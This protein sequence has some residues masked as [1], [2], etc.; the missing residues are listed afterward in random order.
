MRISK[1]DHN[2]RTGCNCKVRKS[3]KMGGTSKTGLHKMSTD[4]T[5]NDQENTSKTCLL[6]TLLVVMH[7]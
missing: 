4:R 6:L 2:N 5:L 1:G 7:H 3:E